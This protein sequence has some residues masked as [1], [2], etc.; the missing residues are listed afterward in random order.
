MKTWHLSNDTYIWLFNVGRGISIFIRTPNNHAIIYD[1]GSSEEF[2]PMDFFKKHLIP[3]IKPFSLKSNNF[4]IAQTIIS[5][6]HLDHIYEV[7]KFDAKNTAF[8]TCPHDKSSEEKFDFSTIEYHSKLDLYKALYSDREPPLQT[9]LY[10]DRNTTVTQAEYG[11]YYIRPPKVKTLHPDNNH[12][13]GNG[14]SIVMYYKYG[15]NSILIPGDITP[16]AMQYLLDER[17]ETQKRYSVFSWQNGG[18]DWESKNSTQPKLIDLLKKHGLTIL[19]P[20]HHG[21]ESCYSEYLASIVKPR[22]NVIS[23]KRTTE[24]EGKID[25]RY[26]SKDGSH[27]MNVE[28]DG[29]KELRNSVTTK[30]AHHYLIKFTYDGKAQVFGAKNAEDL[31]MK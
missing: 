21:L 30:T 11:I 4:P 9:I 29:V 23:E 27:G 22:L 3:S 25:A 16:E 20:A 12:K 1:L 10:N 8:I 7:D 31:L 13:Y 18:K 14:C 2:S 19:V 17:E 6:P 28:V 5:H 15:S 24:N 26:Q